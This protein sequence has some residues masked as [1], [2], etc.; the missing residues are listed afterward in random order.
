M[1]TLALF[2]SP[3][4]TPLVTQTAA[5]T[6]QYT[7]LVNRASLVSGLLCLAIGVYLQYRKRDLHERALATLLHFL[8]TGY[9][10]PK[11]LFLAYCAFYPAMLPQM[12]DYPE[13][14]LV[15]AFCML[16]LAF[17][18]LKAVYAPKAESAKE[19]PPA[20]NS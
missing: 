4:P 7:A 2:Q 16:F 13:A 9:T 1:I 11:A 5:G 14:V 19:P 10:F 18:S 17:S 12:S 15:A 3:L 8:F 6:G 20:Q